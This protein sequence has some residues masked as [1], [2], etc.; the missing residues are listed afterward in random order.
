MFI[1]VLKEQYDQTAKS[2][3]GKKKQLQGKQATA[4]VS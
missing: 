1:D 3:N 4:C 2:K